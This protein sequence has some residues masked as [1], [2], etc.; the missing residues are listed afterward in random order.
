MFRD[1]YSNAD[2]VFV[3]G[4]PLIWISKIF[5]KPI[6]E[7][8]SGSDLFPELC[9]L[10]N[11]KG[12]T[13]FL[14]GAKEGVAKKAAENLQK[15][16]TNLKIVGT[17]S[18]SYGFEK[19]DEEVEQ[20]IRIINDANPDILVV[21]LGAPKQEK[22]IYKYKDRL[23]V[24]ISFGLGATIDF[25]AGNIKRAPKW[26]QRIGLEWFYR[27]CQE[28]KRLFKRYIVDAFEIIRIIIKYRK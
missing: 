22:F 26:M 6:K 1:I 10:A 16:Y 14:F 3:D 5:K 4:M 17:H 27:L 13:M 25:E 24:R 20:V 11:E 15:K 19:N 28:P 21:G 12:Y 8:I 23:D 18:P 9:K 7:K 2:L